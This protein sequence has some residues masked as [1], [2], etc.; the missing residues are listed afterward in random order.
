MLPIQYCYVKMFGHQHL[1]VSSSV[2]SY[3]YHMHIIHVFDIRRTEEEYTVKL[4]L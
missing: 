3:V 1:H 4:L 2:A